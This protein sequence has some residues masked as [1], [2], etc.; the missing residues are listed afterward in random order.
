MNANEIKN[1]YLQLAQN[2]QAGTSQFINSQKQAT[3]NQMNS[4]LQSKYGTNA[5]YNNGSTWY[6]Y[7]NAIEGYDITKDAENMARYNYLQTELD[8]YNKANATYSEASQR[9]ADQQAQNS[10]DYDRAR[11]YGDAALK[12]RGIANQGVAESTRLGISNDYIKANANAYNDYNNNVNELYKNLAEA[13]AEGRS[14]LSNEV[15]AYRNA[16]A[17]IMAEAVNSAATKE[18]LQKYYDKFG[19][20]MDAATKIEYDRKMAQFDNE[21]LMR[22]KGIDVNDN[23]SFENI[24]NSI[25]NVSPA[26]NQYIKKLDDFNNDVQNGTIPNG[27]IVKIGKKN[28]YIYDGKYY[29]TK[30]KPNYKFEK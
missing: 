21:E 12:A 18:D 5:Q 4:L 29:V 17:T 2:N 13:G 23:T 1:K 16:N 9:L 28:Y 10:L 6:D 8:N 11:L 15:A 14:N 26:A 24:Y 20:Y 19:Q 3:L 27:T 25:K 22:D 7:G 30:E